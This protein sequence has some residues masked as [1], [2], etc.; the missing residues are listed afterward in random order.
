MSNA[1]GNLAA[2]ALMRARAQMEKLEAADLSLGADDFDGAYN[3][4][5]EII[6]RTPSPV[7]AWKVG[8]ANAKQLEMFNL[9]EPFFGAVF[10]SDIYQT[11]AQLPAADFHMIGVESEVMFELSKGADAAGPIISESDA[12]DYVAGIR[13]GFEIFSS[14]LNEPFKSGAPALI[15]DCGGNG[16][17]VVGDLV[18]DWR[19]FD[20]ADISAT[21]TVNDEIRGEGTGAIVL[22]N[23][24]KSFH[25]AINKIC[26]MGLS[27]NAGDIIAA[28][29]LTPL[30]IAQPGDRI[31]ADFSSLQKI[32]CTIV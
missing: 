6:S 21:L 5:K 10:A 19:S 4:Q 16:A 29:S 23:P 15:A 11:P 3:I 22:G 17:L 14:R 26:A 31:C 9:S 7:K 12:V 27:L 1:N 20:L 24:L 2:K 18:T 28:G 30:Y 25:W 13:C 8:A 32:E